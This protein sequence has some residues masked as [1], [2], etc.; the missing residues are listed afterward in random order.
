MLTAFTRLGLTQTGVFFC[1]ITYCVTPDLQIA[2]NNLLKLGQEGDTEF[3]REAL[4]GGKP[5]SMLQQKIGSIF[6]VIILMRQV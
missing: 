4:M 5:L 3:A 6:R 2:A 1:F